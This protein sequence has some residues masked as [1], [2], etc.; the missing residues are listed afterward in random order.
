[1]AD[2]ETGPRSHF[3]SIEKKYGKPAEYWLNLLD[4][5]ADRPD[6]Q[7][8]EGLKDEYGLGHDHADALVAVFHSE[9]PH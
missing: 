3:P 1:M 8:V 6:T 9:A 2:K 5:V 4:Q 7:Q